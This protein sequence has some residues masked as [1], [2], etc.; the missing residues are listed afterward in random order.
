MRAHDRRAGPLDEV[1]IGREIRLLLGSPS[2]VDAD[3]IQPSGDVRGRQ[4]CSVHRSATQPYDVGAARVS[5]ASPASM[6]TCPDPPAKSKQRC[7][8]TSCRRDFPELDHVEPSLPADRRSPANA[9][10]TFA[11]RARSIRAIWDLWE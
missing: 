3:E 10:C 2:E 5:S 4:C 6:T 7:S 9:M 11:R 8:A 1:V